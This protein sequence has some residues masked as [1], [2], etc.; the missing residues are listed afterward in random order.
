[1][2]H[3]VA[4]G[5]DGRLLFRTWTEGLALWDRL[6]LGVPGILALTVMPDH[7][8]AVHPRDVRLELARVV[9]SFARWR[10]AHRGESG[11][12]FQPLPEAEWLPNPERRRRT[13]RYVHLNPCRAHL[14]PDPLAWPLSTHRDMVGLAVPRVVPVHRDP[15]DFHRRVSTD[16]TVSVAGTPLPEGTVGTDDLFG[17]RDAVSA[18]TR[19]PSPT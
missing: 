15:V 8:H 18:V 3:L 17:L 5:A 13:V 7:L 19:T 16:P 10:H 14:V 9:A 12:V 1:M 4:R 6:I 11:R 2:Y